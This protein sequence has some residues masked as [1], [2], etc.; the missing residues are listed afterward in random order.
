MEQYLHIAR[1]EVGGGGDGDGIPAG[2]PSALPLLKV[3]HVLKVT[4]YYDFVIFLSRGEIQMLDICL[5]MA[6][7][8]DN[9]LAFQ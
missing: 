5:K 9:K 1:A 6:L 2:H 3:L 7:P 8:I 4:F